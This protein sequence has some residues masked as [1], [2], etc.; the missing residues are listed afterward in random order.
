MLSGAILLY[1]DGWLKCW[2][3]LPQSAAVL[4]TQ[5]NMIEPVCQESA[6]LRAAQKLKV[7]QISFINT[8]PL[9]LPLDKGY[10]KL[11]AEFVAANPAQLNELLSQGQLNIGAMS[12]FFFL[13]D[14]SFELFPDL[15]ISSVNHVGSV[16]L[17]SKCTPEKLSGKVI[18][19]PDSSATSINLLRLLLKEEFGAPCTLIKDPSL[20]L[21]NS[22]ISG[23]L[24]IGDQALKKRPLLENDYHCYDLGAW[25]YR[26]H[27]L[28]MV[29]GLWGARKTW[30]KEN[31]SAFKIIAA[32]FRQALD[33]GLGPYFSQVLDEAEKRSGLEQAR[34]KQYYH[35]D[36]DYRLTEDHL[37][38]LYL[39]ANLCKK[40]GLFDAP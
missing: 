11:E 14:G 12:S 5:T 13:K 4:M 28:P 19:V 10:C 9:T 24:L 27:Q 34:L 8:L 7:G 18:T 17:F 2:S 26:L 35:N 40:H 37:N 1:A 36:L 39:Y 23:S 6:E 29:F 25:W 31:Q 21:A 33:L 16:L 32:G 38:G 22:E 20:S 30:I 3:F 15:S